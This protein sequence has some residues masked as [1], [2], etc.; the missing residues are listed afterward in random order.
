[1]IEMQTTGGQMQAYRRSG[2]VTFSVDG[3]EDRDDALR[4]PDQHDLFVPVP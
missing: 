4:E 1:V 3:R 2:R